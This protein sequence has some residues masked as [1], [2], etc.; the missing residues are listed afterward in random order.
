MHRILTTL[1][2]FV[3]NNQISVIFSNA[4]NELVNQFFVCMT[5]SVSSEIVKLSISFTG[6]IF[7]QQINPST[8]EYRWFSHDIILDQKCG[9][10]IER[11]NVP[12]QP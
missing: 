5:L 6:T 3:L 12:P 10:K 11:H 1:I 4:L 7:Q 9:S 8:S 2:L